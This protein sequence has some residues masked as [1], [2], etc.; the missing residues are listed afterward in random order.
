MSSPCA[1]PDGSGQWRTLARSG[2]RAV[3]IIE[4]SRMQTKTLSPP[5]SVTHQRG[6]PGRSIAHW[7]ISLRSMTCSVG[8]CCIADTGDNAN[9]PPL[10]DG[11]SIRPRA[12][13]EDA[14]DFAGCGVQPGDRRCAPIGRKDLPVVGNRTGN[15]GKVRQRR[16]VCLTIEIDHLQAVPGRVRNEDAARLRVE[17]GV[18]EIAV[19]AL[20]VWR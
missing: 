7:V 14:F 13:R 18:I 1:P 12:G 4:G 15:P 17:G 16:N 6:R 10:Q 8:P 2:S 11:C 5:A 19:Q 9:S 3:R 20:S